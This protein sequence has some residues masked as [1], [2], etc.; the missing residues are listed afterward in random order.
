[1]H[2]LNVFIYI[3]FCSAVHSSQQNS[4]TAQ[5]ACEMPTKKHQDN[6]SSIRNKCAFTCCVWCLCLGVVF[7]L[8]RRHSPAYSA[9]LHAYT[10][11]YFIPKNLYVRCTLRTYNLFPISELFLLLLLPFSLEHTNKLFFSFL[12]EILYLRVATN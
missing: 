8:A 7:F 12:S 10:R 11:I 6:K 4:Y 5:L 3:I 1:M 9:C 2:Y